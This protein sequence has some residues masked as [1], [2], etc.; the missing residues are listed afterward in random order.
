LSSQRAI[1]LQRSARSN[2][3]RRPDRSYHS[4]GNNKGPRHDGGY[5]RDLYLTGDFALV[6]TAAALIAVAG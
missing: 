1:R 3:L 6:F 2:L 4:T 5:R